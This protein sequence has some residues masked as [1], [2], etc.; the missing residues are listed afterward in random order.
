MKKN[1][2]TPKSEIVP[3]RT[4]NII[5]TS[6]GAEQMYTIDGDWDA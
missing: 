2:Q 4:R 3:I 6:G 1:Y 5:L